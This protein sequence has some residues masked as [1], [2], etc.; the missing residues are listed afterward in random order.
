MNFE[1]KVKELENII[2]QLESGEIGFNDATILFEKG[3]EICKT[4]SKEIDEAKGKVTIIRETL[5][6][7]I[8]EE[9]N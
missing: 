6:S 3:S 2:Q 4:L 5:G 9:L 7:M 8:E 1:E